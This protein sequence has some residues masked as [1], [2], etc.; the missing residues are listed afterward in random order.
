M[1]I[2]AAIVLLSTVRVHA[3]PV[4]S[5]KRAVEPEEA[6]CLDDCGFVCDSEWFKPCCFQTAPTMV[7]WRPECCMAEIILYFVM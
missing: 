1:N 5:R 2:C 3:M 6:A 7:L 4:S